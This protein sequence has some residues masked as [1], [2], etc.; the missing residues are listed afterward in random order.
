MSPLDKLQDTLR[1]LF[2]LDEPAELD[3]GVYRLV[4]LKREYLSKYL[5]EQLPQQV[6]A[7]I[8]QTS[9]ATREGELE[10][11][12]LV[13]LATLGK[14]ALDE[15]GEF[16]NSA[17]EETIA[18]EAY[19]NA[20]RDALGIKKAADMQE[21]I[22]DHLATFF[23]RYDCGGGDI[24]PRRRHAVKSRYAVPHDGEEVLLHWA[25]RGQHYI[26]SVA[27]HPNFAFKL[28]GKR[29]VFRITDVRDIPRDNNMDSGRFMLP[30][31]DAIAKEDNGDLLIPFTFRSLNKKEQKEYAVRGKGQKGNGNGNGGKVQAGILAEALTQL[32]ES[33]AK[34]TALTPLLAADENGE[35]AFVRHARRFIR[36]NTADFFIHRD[37]RGFLG[38]ELEFYLKNEALDM[39]ELACINSAAVASRMVV[40]RVARE[41]GLNI[42]DALAQWEDLQKALWEKKK[43]VLQSDYCATLGHIPG[44][45]KTKLFDAITDCK[46]QWADWEQLG[47]SGKAAPLF[48]NGSKRDQ[49]IAYLRENPS[50][51]VDTAHFPPE[52]K[53][54][55]LDQF[56]DIDEVTDGVLIH[57]ENWQALNLMQEMYCGRIDCIHIDPP[58]N[59]ETSGFLY[60]NGFKHSSWMAMMDTRIFA[61]L[62]LMSRDGVF[63]CHIDENEYERLHLLFEQTPTTNAGTVVWD[64]RNPMPGGSGVA[65]QHEYIAVRMARELPIHRTNQS[66][67]SMLSMAMEM[68]KKN[69][70]V[71]DHVRAEFAAWVK[72]NNSLSGGEKA[73]QYLDDEGR[74]YRGVSL[75]APEPRQ[76]PKFHERLIHPVTQKPC[77]IPPNGFSRTPE[78][79]KAMM[80][81]GEIL[82]G[83]DENTQPQQKKFLADDVGPQMPSCIQDGKKGKSYTDALGVSFPYCHPVSLYESLIGSATQSP[84]SFALD[85]FAGSGTTA[86]S[87]IN[88]NRED[89]GQR[90]F[91]LV[92]VGG[93]FSTVL[94][95]RVK[96]LTFSPEWK[97]GKPTR[98]ATVEEFQRGPRLVKYQ[99]IESYEDALSN[100]RFE[101]DGLDFGGAGPYHLQW[102]SRES[103]TWLLDPDMEKP[104]DYLLELT[105]SENGNGGVAPTE[106]A[107]LPE[108]FAYLA[109]LRVKTRRVVMDGKRRYLVQRGMASGKDTV[110]L[111]RDIA[112]WQE[113]DYQR[114][115]DF[116]AKAKLTEGAERILMNGNGALK[117]AESLNPDF[118]R[119]MFAAG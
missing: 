114:E 19:L 10:R 109:G 61:A 80:E 55:L 68:I 20:R 64:K 48:A 65:T 6:D 101:V 85:Y 28:A 32:T 113:K 106:Y 36:R 62:P 87:V 116:I 14:D 98:P 2:R 92:E 16:T 60:K 44:L 56:A 29:F 95:P 117:G 31:I 115:Q 96:K 43:F 99:R 46:A 93:H 108:T 104:F 66:I 30:R 77:A 111:W 11:I 90:K 59:T 71:S 74:I 51:P 21:E 76:D 18:G 103:P 45:E 9:Q 23:S 8:S 105:A 35:S 94:L 110:V 83:P 25:N 73:Y 63:Q 4:N 34:N 39:E 47:L 22:Y 7:E 57:G 38:A 88:L 52:F 27:Y 97:D 13:L 67:L 37:L 102:D 54:Q 33:A 112:G 1:R 84:S 81:K 100:I 82:F 41:L 17:F 75:R 24:V 3:F 12:R 26:K 42:I 5:D 49:R 58:Y 91:I 119:R 40:V 79:L 78:T 107:D 53:D 86:H 50:L 118:G 70:G 72:A 69:G 15:N 89:G